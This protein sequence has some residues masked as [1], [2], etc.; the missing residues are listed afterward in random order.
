ME[1]AL[2]G[3][4]EHSPLEVSKTILD[5]SQLACTQSFFF[6]SF[7]LTQTVKAQNALQ[8]TLVTI[9]HPRDFFSQKIREISSFFLLF[10]KMISWLWTW[11]IPS[12]SH[13]HTGSVVLCL[14]LQA[15][16]VTRTVSWVWLLL[17]AL[18]GNKP[19]LTG[20]VMI[21]A[22][23]TKSQTGKNSRGEF[24]FT[25]CFFKWL[26]FQNEAVGKC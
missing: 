8:A 26:L 6:S 23:I 4:G 18:S 10:I 12:K 15:K 17:M 9:G 1:P 20:F 16:A 2:I 19:G 24:G 5:P 25:S 21:Q 22:V 11:S 3:G 14:F 13:V 7:P